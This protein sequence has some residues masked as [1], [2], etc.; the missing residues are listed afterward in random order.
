MKYDQ[1]SNI[2][3]DEMYILNHVYIFLHMCTMRYENY[4]YN[5]FMK[6]I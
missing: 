4:Y 1:I 3:K 6:I 5:E 2:I